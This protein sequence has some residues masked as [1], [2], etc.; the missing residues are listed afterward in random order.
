[1]TAIVN[2]LEQDGLVSKSQHPAD[3]RVVLVEITDSGR[4]QLAEIRA[5]RAAVLQTRLDRLDDDARAALAA[6][7]PA[8]DQLLESMTSLLKQP[9]SVYAVAFAC[10]VAFMGIGL[11]D[12]ILPVLAKD[13]QASPSQVSLLFTSYF[14]MTGLS[15]LVTGFV[16]SRIGP[17]KTLLVGL[18]AGRPLQRARRPLR[19]GR[20][21]RRLPP[22]LGPRQR[23][24]HRH[25]AVG[26]R[27][28]RQRRAR[29]GD[30]P[31]RGRARPGHRLRPAA[32][33]PARR[34]LLARPVLRHRDADG[35]RLRADRGVARPG[36]QARAPRLDPGPAARPRPQRA[37]LDGDR[38]RPLQLRLLHDPRLHAA[39]ARHDRHPARAHL[40]RVGP[41][42]R[43]QLRVRRPAPG[44]PVRARV[45]AGRDAGA[46][47]PWTCSSAVSSTATGPA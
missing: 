44:A 28:R 38:R 30:H 35:D 39:A 33:R 19:H 41:A 1:M 45:R 31:L 36:R 12:P 23:A 11:V 10:V 17:R 15:M 46:W 18:V 16:A 3:A 2:R 27:R 20:P 32:R 37:A 43:D 6:A 47:S 26:D 22:R 5:A 42:G 21:D 13:L 9:R 4:R 14:A 34:R 8:L 7:L 25:R 40:L 24:V 29:L